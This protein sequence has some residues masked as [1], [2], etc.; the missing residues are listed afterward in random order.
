MTSI[1]DAVPEHRYEIVG[2]SA[3]PFALAMATAVVF[4]GVVFTP[5]ALPVGAVC[6]FLSL[7]GWFWHVEPWFLRP[8][9]LERY[10]QTPTSPTAIEEPI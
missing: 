7:L 5:W 3:W 8:E 10:P 4:I 9:A 1:V 2:P 6:V